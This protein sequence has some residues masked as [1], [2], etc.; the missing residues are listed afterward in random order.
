MANKNLEL[1]NEKI[2]DDAL[3]NV[4]FNYNVDSPTFLSSNSE[5]INY[6]YNIMMVSAAVIYKA[7]I[8]WKNNHSEKDQDKII[9]EMQNSTLRVFNLL[10]QLYVSRSFDIDFV[11]TLMTNIQIDLNINSNSNA[12]RIMGLEE[13]MRLNGH[14]SRYFYLYKQSQLSSRED[15]S[16]T[17][18]QC[19]DVIKSFKYLKEVKSS[20]KQYVN[21][22]KLKTLSISFD[23]ISVS[24]EDILLIKGYYVYILES[25]DIIDNKRFSDS[26]FKDQILILNY[27][28]IDATKK[29]I[30][31]VYNVQKNIEDA[32]G[33]LSIVE[34]LFI[35]RFLDTYG[36]SQVQP[37]T[38]DAHFIKDYISFDN[39]YIKTF[40]IIISD[41]LTLKSKQKI[42]LDYTRRYSA[43]FEH[44]KF[45]SSNSNNVNNYQWDE[46]VLFLLLEVGISK[47][48]CY[49]LNNNVIQV[50]NITRQLKTTIGQRAIELITEYE[51]TGKLSG[52]PVEVV[53][54]NLI[55]IATKLFS[56]DK[57]YYESSNYHES[58]TD[59]IKET[60]NLL[61]RSNN[62][63]ITFMKV[64]IKSLQALS[65]LSIFYES[66][67]GYAKIKSYWDMKLKGDW[68]PTYNEYKAKKIENLAQFSKDIELNKKN[69]IKY[70]E[71]NNYEI[72]QNYV[73][74][75]IELINQS[76]D[77]F[78]KVNDNISSREN[79]AN[80]AFN[81]IVGRK[82]VFSAEVINKYRRRIVSAYEKVSAKKNIKFTKE[83]LSDIC[84]PILDFYSYLGGYNNT[85]RD[86]ESSI[87]PITATYS[88]GVI[89]EDGYRYSYFNIC[90]NLDRDLVKVKMI[91]DGDF[92]FGE[93]YYCLPNVN[94]TAKLNIDGKEEYT[95]VDPVVIPYE[96]YKKDHYYDEKI[97]LS[98]EPLDDKSDYEKVAGLVFD[99]EITAYTKLFGNKENAV[100][101]LSKMFD[102][103]LSNYHKD[104]FYVLKCNKRI[105]GTVSMYR[106]LK[107]WNSEYVL[108]AFKQCNIEVP[109]TFKEAAISFMDTF[110]DSMGEMYMI[111]DV[112]IDESYRKKGYATYLLKY[113]NNIARSEGKNTFLTVYRD[114]A[115]AIKLY[116]ELGFIRY[117][118]DYD[119]RGI[120]TDFD[121]GYYKMVMYNIV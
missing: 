5:Y 35:E 103:E 100:R 18:D 42:I 82:E 93:Y 2:R 58:I 95:W 70:V 3:K 1:I 87:Y 101:V 59:I 56:I 15:I 86:I 50:E 90:K 47:F 40:S 68:M 26:E 22:H 37:K 36:I 110:D 39:K 41:C 94:R 19:Y 105:I 43:V 73:I 81:N 121:K 16:F 96:C 46:L 20:E 91:I 104:N 75:A 12:L 113:I 9:Q 14:I 24:L 53:V 97:E 4:L 57:V 77:D 8:G 49:L 71:L 63:A 112:C 55:N 34:D 88:N 27:I 114:N 83:T 64:T 109:E 48:L 7:Y 74:K 65:F 117:F 62:Y 116:T 78:I 29:L 76:F 11:E 98:V 54:R 45:K 67:I 119:N 99:S 6:F 31:K 38:I 33:V 107:K 51:M 106:M 79:P 115:S 89:T 111:S 85:G 102:N 108:K 21:E 72:N 120:G 13:F 60:E 28:S 23:D 69:H 52:Q 17:F 80:I 10:N 84:K 61:S 25:F 92:D 118:I 66:L 32:N 30:I 44:M